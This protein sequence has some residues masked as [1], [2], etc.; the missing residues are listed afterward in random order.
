MMYIWIGVLFAIAVLHML[1]PDK[2]RS[3]MIRW[4]RY[5]DYLEPAAGWRAKWTNH[6][7]RALGWVY[8]IAAI[9]MLLL[10]MTIQ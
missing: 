4:M 5:W 10:T 8:A 6:Y 9:V 2:I 7:I 3:L 1:S